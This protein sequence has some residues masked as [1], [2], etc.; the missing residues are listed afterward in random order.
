[1]KV[2]LTLRYG[3]SISGLSGLAGCESSEHGYGHL[4]GRRNKKIDVLKYLFSKNCSTEIGF[5]TCLYRSYLSDMKGLDYA[6][7]AEKCA[8]ILHSKANSNCANNSIFAGELLDPMFE[9]VVLKATLYY[10]QADFAETLT[11]VD[12]VAPKLPPHL[13]VLL[14][15]ISEVV[16]PVF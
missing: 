10:L 11:L 16:G 9:I 6:L 7:A 5:Q 15:F 4:G 12:E 2:I 8:K 1:M 13:C 3:N 14:W